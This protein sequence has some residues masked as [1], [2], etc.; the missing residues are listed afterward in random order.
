MVNDNLI[1]DGPSTIL[2]NDDEICLGYHAYTYRFFLK[3][4]LPQNLQVERLRI[5]DA[6][7][8]SLKFIGY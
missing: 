6:A 8:S 4:D 1:K 7:V 3:T 5:G 2:N